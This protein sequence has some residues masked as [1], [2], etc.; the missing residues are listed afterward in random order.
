MHVP[1]LDYSGLWPRRA[2]PFRTGFFV[3]RRFQY[4]VLYVFDISGGKPML[5]TLLLVVAFVLFLL[6]AFGVPVV[7]PRFNLIAGGL[8]CWVLA[9]LM[10]MLR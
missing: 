9:S 1:R 10:P 8:A 5:S 2:E 3:A 6:A 7:P 4:I